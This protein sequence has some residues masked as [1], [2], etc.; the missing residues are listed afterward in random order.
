[1]GRRFF[2]QQ[3]RTLARQEAAAHPERWHMAFLERNH[4]LVRL[5]EPLDPAGGSCWLRHYP[6]R[7]L[8][9][10]RFVPTTF[11]ETSEE[12]SSEEP[13]SEE[14]SSATEAFPETVLPAETLSFAATG[15][16]APKSF[17]AKETDPQSFGSSFPTAKLGGLLQSADWGYDAYLSGNYRLHPLAEAP[18]VLRPDPGFLVARSLESAAQA[19]V[20]A[21]DRG[22]QRLHVVRRLIYQHWWMGP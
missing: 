21:Q 16:P 15:D 6:P 2:R 5:Q 4:P 18:L 10:R 14:P 12:G 13:S 20:T 9:W 8:L 19:I 7:L 1:M 11:P 22:L 17:P 3:Q